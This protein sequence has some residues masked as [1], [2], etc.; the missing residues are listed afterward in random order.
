MHKTLRPAC[1]RWHVSTTFDRATP[2]VPRDGP[3]HS[4][5]AEPTS[6]GHLTGGFAWEDM[7]LASGPSNGG[8]GKGLLHA[9]IKEE[10]S[11]DL[12]EKLPFSLNHG[13]RMDQLPLL[14]FVGE[15]LSPSSET[16]APTLF[17][18][19]SRNRAYDHLRLNLIVRWFSLARLLSAFRDLIRLVPSK[20]EHQ[21]L[22]TMW[23][24]KSALTM[25][26][27]PVSTSAT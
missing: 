9:D 19:L 25:L 6:S 1:S 18:S 20:Q 26:M 5:A 4:G 8:P 12:P 11:G 3:N 17:P 15:G 10:A 22:E 14:V 27:T 16:S 24:T 21:T 7:R 13:Q 2:E 23:V